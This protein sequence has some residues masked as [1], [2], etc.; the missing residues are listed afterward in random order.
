MFRVTTYPSKCIGFSLRNVASSTLDFFPYKTS[1]KEIQVQF[2]SSFTIHHIKLY[3]QLV[4]RSISFFKAVKTCS[5]H[6]LLA[7]CVL[8]QVFF[9]AITSS[10]SPF[11]LSQAFK[12]LQGWRFHSLPQEPM[13]VLRYCCRKFFD[14]LREPPVLEFVY[15]GTCPL[16][17]QQ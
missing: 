3:A 10:S 1:C 9:S 15:I 11:G 4:R 7:K 8:M 12:C 17:G 6:T 16:T 5:D 2:Y 14:A 13:P